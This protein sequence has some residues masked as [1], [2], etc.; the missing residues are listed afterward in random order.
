MRQPPCL[1]P[2]GI[3]IGEEVDSKSIALQG[4]AGSSPVP[5][6]ERENG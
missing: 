4:V 6:A 1:L 5:S 3:R 2:E